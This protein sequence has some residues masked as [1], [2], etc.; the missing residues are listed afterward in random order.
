[1]SN[2]LRSF[3]HPALRYATKRQPERC[4]YIYADA[5]ED[6]AEDTQQYFILYLYFSSACNCYVLRE[7]CQAQRCHL[8]LLQ[9]CLALITGLPALLSTSYS[10]QIKNAIGMFIT[11]YLYLN[12][13]CFC[14][15]AKM[16]YIVIKRKHLRTI[17]ARS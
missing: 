8:L 13:F 7:R 12:G 3:V 14:S 11:C 4:H 10:T 9:A 17:Y 15:A 6:A 16:L 5:A 2:A 1:M